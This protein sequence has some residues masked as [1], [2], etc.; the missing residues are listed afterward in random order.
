MKTLTYAIILVLVL[1]ANRNTAA[2]EVTHSFLVCGEKTYIMGG[3][4]PP[5]A[6][7]RRTPTNSCKCSGISG[8]IGS[9]PMRAASELNGESD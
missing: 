1:S 3:I 6:D 5:C 9:F 2:Q 4:P 7:V 8:R